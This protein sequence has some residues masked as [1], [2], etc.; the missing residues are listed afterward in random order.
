MKGKYKLSKT[1]NPPANIIDGFL[2]SQN[3]TFRFI[4][5]ESSDGADIKVESVIQIPIENFQTYSEF[6]CQSVFIVEGNPV[7]QVSDL[8]R[9]LMTEII[10]E[11]LAI[12]AKIVLDAVNFPVVLPLFSEVYNRLHYLEK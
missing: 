2:L 1:V 4:L 7:K 11:Q 12:H 8:N 3:I 10:C 6:N 5:V 9:Y